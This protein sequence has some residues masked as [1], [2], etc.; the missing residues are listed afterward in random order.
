[1]A[2]SLSHDHTKH[3]LNDFANLRIDTL[4]TKRRDQYELSVASEQDIAHLINVPV[5]DGSVKNSLEGW[6]FISFAD[7]YNDDTRVL[8]I[9]HDADGMSWCTSQ[10]LAFDDNRNLVRT[11]SGSLYEVIGDPVPEPSQDLV[12]HVAATFKSW[13]LGKPLGMPVVFY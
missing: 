6:C 5:G 9:G 3:I 13:G 11:K 4:I 8:L 12:L 7:T 1:M 10:V 2:D